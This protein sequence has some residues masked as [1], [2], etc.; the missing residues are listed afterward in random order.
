MVSLPAV[1][2]F[3]IQQSHA[4]VKQKAVSAVHLQQKLTALKKLVAPQGF[5]PRYYGPEPHVLPLDEGA[6]IYN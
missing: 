3:F 6:K 5:E 4:K 1:P 2:S